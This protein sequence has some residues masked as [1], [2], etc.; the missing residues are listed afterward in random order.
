MPRKFQRKGKPDGPS[1]SRWEA[2]RHFPAAFLVTTFALFTVGLLFQRVLVYAFLTTTTYV[3]TDVALSGFLSTGPGQV[4]IFRQ[5]PF[6]TRGYAFYVIIAFILI[7]APLLAL[8]V[9]YL[10]PTLSQVTAPFGAYGE[11]A[12]AVGF[13]CGSTLVV[14]AYLRW[15]TMR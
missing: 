2:F 13:A 5:N 4:K 15:L 3:L 7:A 12:A 10:P 11:V 14:Y 1:R 6:T 8:A 9:S